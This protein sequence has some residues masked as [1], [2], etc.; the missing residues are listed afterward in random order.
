MFND[1]LFFSFNIKDD[2]VGL[3]FYSGS[4]N[5]ILFLM[6]SGVADRMSVG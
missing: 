5:L 4:S 6:I 2:L 1:L 3:T